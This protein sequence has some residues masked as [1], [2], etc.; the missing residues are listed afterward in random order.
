MTS[1]DSRGARLLRPDGSPLPERPESSILLLLKRIKGV[2]L[3]LVAGL[4]VLGGVAAN[5]DR[6]R[7][8]LPVS[9]SD[10]TQRSS[11][12]SPL[13][14][15]PDVSR[16]AQ[17]S[18]DEPP[19]VVEEHVGST[20][21]PTNDSLARLAVA[22]GQADTNGQDVTVES[23]LG[24]TKSLNL[25]QENLPANFSPFADWRPPVAD[26]EIRTQ[27]T[28]SISY[29]DP[30]ESVRTE[31]FRGLDVGIR[32]TTPH[33][34]PVIDAG[35]E[36]ELPL[37]H[38]RRIEVLDPIPH[39]DVANWPRYFQEQVPRITV[40]VT[41]SGG[42]VSKYWMY[43]T[44][45][46]YYLAED[47][48]VRGLHLCRVKEVII[49]PELKA[50]TFGQPGEDHVEERFIE[51]DGTVVDKETGLI[52]TQ[53]D[54]AEVVWDEAQRYCGRLKLGDYRDW[55]LPT[56]EELETLYHLS[57]NI[58]CRR[59][60]SGKETFIDEDGYL[61]A[62][63]FDFEEDVERRLPM[64]VS[65]PGKGCGFTALSALCVYVKS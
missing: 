10:T 63:T 17:P 50:G 18:P 27:F 28:G 34:L 4:G 64:C 57:G 37:K 48:T 42:T 55:R 13:L 5:L 38:I 35:I 31:K 20:T 65:R 16:R 23:Q 22:A 61:M 46:W 52:W 3:A 59:W 15:N 54:K 41:D 43:A 2:S 51:K 33:N 24:S 58:T 25:A 26:R 45:W 32:I 44:H 39:R 19:E 9:T 8:W 12:E 11:T 56:I 60:K 36:V 49:S 21:P 7:T 29:L 30:D 40:L 53:N 6:I 14:P 1:K 47:F 62:Q